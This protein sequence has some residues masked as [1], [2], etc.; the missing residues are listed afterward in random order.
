MAV[1][2]ATFGARLIVLDVARL[3]ILAITAFAV[4]A[5]Q[6]ADAVDTSSNAAETEGVRVTGESF[7]LRFSRDPDRFR[8]REF[9]YAGGS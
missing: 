3:S 4:I 1:C 2:E 9:A 8:I 7:R 5:I 6:E